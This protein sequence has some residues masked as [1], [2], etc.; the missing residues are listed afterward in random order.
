MEK[1]NNLTEDLTRKI[2]EFLYKD[3]AMNVITIHYFENIKSELGELYICEID[4]QIKTLLHIKDDGNSHF[5][6]ICVDDEKYL[7]QIASKIKEINYKDLLLAAKDTEVAIILKHMGR[8]G[9]LY[10][11]TYY[12]YESK[13]LFDIEK[14][15]F[16]LKKAR[17][18]DFEI[19][20]KLLIDF[21][22]ADSESSKERISANIKLEKIR[23]LYKGDTVIGF[24]SFFGYSKNYIDISSVYISEPY[25]GLGYSKLLMKYMIKES[26]EKGKIAVLQASKTNKKANRTYINTGFRE[27]S[28]YAF[29][30]VNEL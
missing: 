3:E 15:E 7:E 12:V 8:A 2:L 1:I 25:R 29:Q 18:S 26:L 30:F 20:E 28:D 22:E 19:V 10:L 4:K 27:M 11:N 24:G 5:T 13:E 21:F 6:T 14:S 23:L 16:I 17:Q 9:E